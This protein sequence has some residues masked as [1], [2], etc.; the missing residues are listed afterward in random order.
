MHPGCPERAST[1]P[2]GSSPAGATTAGVTLPVGAVEPL[3]SAPTQARCSTLNLGRFSSEPSQAHITRDD[4]EPKGAP[5][6]PANLHV[7]SPMM[8]GPDVLQIQQ[9]LAALG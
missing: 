1:A 3:D 7:T 4:S 9:K 2:T 6:M 5:R 8:S